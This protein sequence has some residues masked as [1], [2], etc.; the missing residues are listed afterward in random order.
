MDPAHCLRT[1]PLHWDHCHH[2]VDDKDSK[3]Q[4]YYHFILAA[5]EFILSWEHC[6]LSIQN[7][8]K[9]G[10]FTSPVL[11]AFLLARACLLSLRSL[12]HRSVSLSPV[13]ASTSGTMPESSRLIAN[14]VLQRAPHRRALAHVE[15]SKVVMRT[16]PV[17][18][19]LRPW[20]AS[21]LC[22]AQQV[23]LLQTGNTR[24]PAHFL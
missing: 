12:A 7:K 11:C 5:A 14:Q 6:L 9:F 22:E 15:K 8:K 2:S 18:S 23:R 16:S 17:R 3:L 19:S 24:P 21:G 10:E 20:S 4:H 1:L 13:P